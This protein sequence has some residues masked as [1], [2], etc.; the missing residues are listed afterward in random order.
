MF[1][2]GITQTPFTTEAANAYF[3]NITGGSFNHDHSFISTLRALLAPRIKEGE[4]VNLI[5]GSSG[6]NLDQVGAIPAERVVSA[7]CNDY[8]LSYPGQFIV[9]S[10][11]AGQESNMAN[12]KAIEVKFASVYEGY[13]RLGKVKDFYRK[14]FNL[15]CYINPDLKS[16]IV[17]VENLDN[18]KMHYLQ[19]SILAMFPWYFNP[20]EGMTDDEM[21]LVYSLRETSPDKYN[22][23]LAKMASQYDFKSARVRQLLAGFETRYEKMAC[24]NV[25]EE[26]AAHDRKIAELNS[27]IGDHFR[28]RNESCIRLLGL[29]QKIAEGSGDSEIMEYFLCNDHLVLENV[30]DTDMYFSVKDYLEYFDSE[31]AERAIGNR[32]SFVYEYGLAARGDDG[33]DKAKKL[34]TEIFVSENP[35]LR[36]RFCAAYLF[37]LNGNVQPLSGHDFGFEFNGYMPNTHINN[38][39]C[40]GGYETTINKLLVKRNY[41]GAIEQCIASCKSLNWGD[42]TVMCEFMRQFWDSRNKCIE[43]PDGTVVCPE[44]AFNW[45]EAQDKPVETEASPDEQTKEES[46]DEQAN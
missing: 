2:A 7:I 17:F 32:G 1:K 38:F 15:D 6:Y 24:D 43:L 18:K 29:E 26:I 22:Q 5:F 14:A 37:N 16:V 40:M 23:C 33:R 12:F 21:A 10:L 9:H 34:M 11:R 35:R 30:T 44:E 4:S 36:V 45:L 3:S 42:H 39:R 8:R 31:M 19:V 13:H 41:I 27:Y 20:K 25:R 46:Q 28:R